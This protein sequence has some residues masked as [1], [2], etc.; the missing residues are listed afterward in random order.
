[1]NELRTNLKLFENHNS[2]T[3][4]IFNLVYAKNRG[5]D[6]IPKL[7]SLRNKNHVT[8]SA[9]RYSTVLIMLNKI[10]LSKSRRRLPWK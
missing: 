9:E 7:A 10:I 5:H 1:L 4:E 2:S 8:I 6:I 3:R